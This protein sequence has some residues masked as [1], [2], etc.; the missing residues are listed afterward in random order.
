MNGYIQA[1]KYFVCAHGCCT[2]VSPEI[3]HYSYWHAKT[4]MAGILLCMAEAVL[5]IITGDITIE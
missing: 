2:Q 3:W 5:F 4:A 1:G